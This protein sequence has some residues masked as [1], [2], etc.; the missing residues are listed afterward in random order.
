MA[1]KT[2]EP[3]LLRAGDKAELERLTRA[4]TAPAAAAQRARIVLL[5][6]EG[7][8]NYLIAER[9]G[10]TRPTV[11]LWR[12]RYRERG[13]AGLVDENRPDR[14]AASIGLRSSPPR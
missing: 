4:S 2:A 3:L 11:N 14:P 13:L 8:A 7:T 9:V 1:N 10:V 5:A 6:A 12:A